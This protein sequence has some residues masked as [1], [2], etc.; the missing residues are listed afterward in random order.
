MNV[1]P[2]KIKA[3]MTQVLKS[4][5]GKIDPRMGIFDFL[6]LDFLIDEEL[7]VW[8]I[9]TNVNPA[10]HRNSTVLDERI[11]KAVT[12]AL[13]IVLEVH[14][15]QRAKEPLLPFVADTGEWEVLVGP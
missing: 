6:G 5:E 2:E 7:N 3:I 14:E 12:T 13:D 9:E 11:T 4:I 8:F 1:L 15:K 10:L